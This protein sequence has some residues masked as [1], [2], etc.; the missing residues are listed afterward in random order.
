MAECTRIRD[1]IVKNSAIFNNPDDFSGSVTVENCASDDGDGTNAVTPSDWSD[2]FEDYSNGDFRLKATDTDLIGAGLDLST[3]VDYPFKDD[4]E[5][6]KRG[7]NGSW[8]IGADEYVPTEI[9]RSVG[10]GSTDALEE[11]TDNPMT[12]VGDTAT[13]SSALANNI[14][15]GDA[16][17]YDDDV[18]GDIDSDDSIVFIDLRI[19]NYEF[20]V[21]KAYG[22]L[23]VEV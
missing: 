6:Q 9:Y 13:F 11:G 19:S 20:R 18:D 23:P 15:V 14:G 2:V 3:D 7:F 5:G 4:I 21:K 17:Q 22:S 8:D 16:I 1:V 12:I 10:P